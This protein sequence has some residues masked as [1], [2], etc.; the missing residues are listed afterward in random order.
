MMQGEMARCQLIKNESLFP[1][2]IKTEKE[3]EEEEGS[4]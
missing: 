1:K 4:Q 3:E 2:L